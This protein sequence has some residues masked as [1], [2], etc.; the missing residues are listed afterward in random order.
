MLSIPSGVASWKRWGCGICILVLLAA[1]LMQ[2]THCCNPRA[3]DNGTEGITF[4]SAAPPALCL[5][6]L[7]AQSSGVVMLFAIFGSLL[8]AARRPG[9]ATPRLRVLC[10]CF[11]L[12]VRPPPVF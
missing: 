6:C 2:A 12:D 11:R 8:V 4:L 7:M 9:L 10:E 1:S 5:T 3:L